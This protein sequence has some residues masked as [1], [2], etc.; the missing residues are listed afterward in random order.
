M[1]LDVWKFL[2]EAVTR[3][4]PVTLLIP[5]G[6]TGERFASRFVGNEPD[7]SLWIE[8]CRVRHADPTVARAGLAEGQSC[9]I[10]FKCQSSLLTFDSLALR[11]DA[12]KSLGVDLCVE[13]VLL[14]KPPSMR[15]LQR[16][17]EFRAAVAADGEAL[18]TARVWRASAKWPTS[19]MSRRNWRKWQP[20]SAT[21]ARGAPGWSWGAIAGSNP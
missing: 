13:A 1:E 15:W 14:S 4:A 18:L 3:N 7:G 20:S 10:A 21:S 11:C 9:S 2:D 6:V 8:Q 16:R 5:A 17:N 19:A 12:E